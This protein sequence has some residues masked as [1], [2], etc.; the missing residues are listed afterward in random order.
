[1]AEIEKEEERARGT[2]VRRGESGIGA[3]AREI[4]RGCKKDGRAISI[5]RNYLSTRGGDD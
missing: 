3:E 2:V 4:R 1:M 5:K